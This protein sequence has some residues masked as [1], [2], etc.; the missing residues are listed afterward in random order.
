MIRRPP[1]STLFPYT[2]LF[3][4]RQELIGDLGDRQV[5]DVELV[6]ADQVQ[7]QVERAG[8][9]L[10]LDDETGLLGEHGVRRGGSG[11]EG[12]PPGRANWPTS[13]H[14][15]PISWRAGHRNGVNTTGA[16]HVMARIGRNPSAYSRRYLNPMSG[17][18][19][20]LN[21]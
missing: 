6:L 9:L 19:R 2:T 13:D 18:S 12:T 11:H 16:S 5:G 8:E 3:R 7:Q 14:P 15:S 10:Q 20:C 21:T 4:S 1:R 17:G